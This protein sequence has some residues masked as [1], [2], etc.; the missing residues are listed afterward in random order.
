MPST[1][2]PT[3]PNERLVMAEARELG[4]LEEG[5]GAVRLL[6]QLLDEL[7]R[8]GRQAE[9]HVD[10]V[11]QPLLEQFVVVA[12]RRLER[13]DHVADHILRGVVQ[14]GRQP[15]SRFDVGLDVG[16]DLLDHH[17]VLGHGEGVLAHRLA[18]PAGHAGEAVGDVLDLDV[19]RRGVQQVEP[20]ARKHALPRPRGFVGATQPFPHR[21][22]PSMV[23]V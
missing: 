17:R 2:R 10:G 16:D 12:Q 5:A 4:G 13:A 22:I 18:V 21:L 3:T 6:D 15:P 23:W 19:H 1:I 8:P 14:Q 7:R 20:A 9:A 11:L